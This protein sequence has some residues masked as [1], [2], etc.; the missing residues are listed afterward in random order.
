MGLD[1]ARGR[2]SR[3]VSRWR[4]SSGVARAEGVRVAHVKPHGALYNQAARDPALAC[5]HRARRRDARCRGW[6]SSASRV[7]DARRG[8]AG[9]PAGRGRGV[10]RSRLPA[11]RLARA[12]EPVTDRRDSRSRGRRRARRAHRAGRAR[13]VP[14]WPARM[15]RCAPI[16]SASTATRRARRSWRAPDPRGA[17]A[18]RRP[19]LAPTSERLHSVGQVAESHDA[20]GTAKH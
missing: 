5:G 8:A 4:R 18:C 19:R 6:C 12:A 10:R 16:R 3:P 7:C 14:R 20:G 11:R 13:D 15:S 2:G 1:P 17:R 9:G